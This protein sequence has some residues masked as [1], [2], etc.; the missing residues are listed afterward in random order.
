MVGRVLDDGTSQIAETTYNSQG[1]VTSRTDPLGRRTSC[2][3][4]RSENGHS[5]TLGR[6]LMLPIVR[7]LLLKGQGCA[8]R[9]LITDQLPQTRRFKSAAHV[10]RFAS[11]HGL[12]Q[13]LFRVGPHL[14]RA[15]HHRLLRR[16]AFRAWDAVTCAC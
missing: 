4:V 2:V 11:V 12:V 14:L 16:E 8:P 7:N 6:P 1:Q 5:A 15:A 9:Q 10:Q 13:N 3:R